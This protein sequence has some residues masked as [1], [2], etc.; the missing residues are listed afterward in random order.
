MFVE[1]EEKYTIRGDDLAKGV[2]LLR[3]DEHPLE[4]FDLVEDVV[5]L[6]G[7][8]FEGSRIERLRMPPLMSNVVEKSIGYGDNGI[9]CLWQNISMTE[10][11]SGDAHDLYTLT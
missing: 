2:F 9:H 10:L 11:R 5:P 1:R 7:H 4:S 3:Q 6:T 8:E